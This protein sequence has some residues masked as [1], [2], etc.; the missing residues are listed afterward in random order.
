MPS[1][2]IGCRVVHNRSGNATLA[3][4]DGARDKPWLLRTSETTF[5]ASHDEFINPDHLA[6]RQPLILEAA[7][8]LRKLMTDMMAAAQSIRTKP[9]PLR[10]SA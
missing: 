1:L 2:K 6:K 9:S 8:S 10:P 7:G 4:Y 5:W 3:S